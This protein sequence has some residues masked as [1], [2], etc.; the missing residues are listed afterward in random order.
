VRAV[1]ALSEHRGEDTRRRDDGAEE[2]IQGDVMTTL[3]RGYKAT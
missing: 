1:T 3:R 2:R